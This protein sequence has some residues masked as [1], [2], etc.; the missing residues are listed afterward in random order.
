MMTA[1]QLVHDGFTDAIETSRDPVVLFMISE[2]P[3]AGHHP[4]TEHLKILDI[5]R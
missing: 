4:V 1:I 5:D 2:L 3:A